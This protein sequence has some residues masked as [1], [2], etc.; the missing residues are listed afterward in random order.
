MPPFLRC[1]DVFLLCGSRLL[2]NMPSSRERSGAIP[3]R[4]HQESAMAC[5]IGMSTDVPAREREFG[6]KARILH[7]GLTYEEANTLEHRERTVCGSHCQ[8]RTGGRYVAGRVWS[9]YRMDW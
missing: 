7:T 3:L 5:R 2:L 6:H 4:N 9:V 8:G 1:S